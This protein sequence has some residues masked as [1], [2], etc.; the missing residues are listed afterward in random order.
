MGFSTLS[1]FDV[2]AFTLDA[3]VGFDTEFVERGR[4]EGKQNFKIAAELGVPVAGGQAYAGASAVVMLDDVHVPPSYAQHGVYSSGNELFS[5][6]QPSGGFAWGT[7]LGS[8]NRA[9]PYIGFS[10]DV[11]GWFTADVGFIAHFHTNIDY[12]S[13][14]P[15]SVTGSHK[16]GEGADNYLEA[17]YD[18]AQKALEMWNAPRDSREIY[19]GAAA[20]VIGAPKAY[21][22]YDFDREELN[23][24]ISASYG[25]D[26]GSLGFNHI[27]IEGSGRIGYDYAQRPYG[28]KHYFD[29]GMP[30][31]KLAKGYFYFELGADLV[32]KYNEQASI[33]TGVRY[34]V[35][36]N[37]R[38]GWA[39]HTFADCSDSA[40]HLTEDASHECGPFA[41]PRSTVWFTS[42]IEFSF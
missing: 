39:N 40:D 8:A 2:P 17:Y 1:A 11:S 25:Y 32:Y 10:R 16:L 20:D 22:Y 15:N 6:S 42:S 41:R 7:S 23:A 12:I 31:C 21:L 9:S 19:I 26:L 33:K 34:S 24:V 38:G 14:D 5:F 13:F 28:R 27:V 36:G 29:E 18:L 30:T 3:K 35:N 4:K 37:S